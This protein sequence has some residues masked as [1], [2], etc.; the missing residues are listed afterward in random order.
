MHLLVS[1]PYYHVVCLYV[2]TTISFI[3]FLCF[4]II[5]FFIIFCSFCLFHHCFNILVFFVIRS[6]TPNP[7]VRGLVGSHNIIV[8]YHCVIVVWI[9]VYLP[10]FVVY[11]I[12]YPPHLITLLSLV[13]V[14]EA[15]NRVEP[16]QGDQSFCCLLA[17]FNKKVED[18]LKWQNLRQSK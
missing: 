11:S 6:D 4:N 13:G 5:L 17:I 14:D 15:A 16:E 12:I 2:N 7:L 10:I 18:D 3:I 8:R 9:I 1:F